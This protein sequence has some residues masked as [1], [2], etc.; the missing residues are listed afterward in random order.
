MEDKNLSTVLKYIE[1]AKTFQEQRAHHCPLLTAPCYTTPIKL[2]AETF[3]FWGAHLE[4][5]PDNDP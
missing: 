2:I 1:N 3:R 5:G 4:Q